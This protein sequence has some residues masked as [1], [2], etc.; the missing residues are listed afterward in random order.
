MVNGIGDIMINWDSPQKK[1]HGYRCPAFHCFYEGKKND[2]C[3][4]HR[5]PLILT[6]GYDKKSKYWLLRQKP[7]TRTLGKHLKD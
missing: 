4:K 6:Y 3:P 1:I 2:I 5:V 7:L